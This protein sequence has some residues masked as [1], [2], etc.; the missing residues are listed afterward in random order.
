[1]KKIGLV[2]IGVILF[3]LIGT[4]FQAYFY[5]NDFARKHAYSKVLEY[6]ERKD[7]DPATLKGTISHETTGK[8]VYHFSWNYDDSGIPHTVGVWIAPDGYREIYSGRND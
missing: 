5:S 1:M 6:C 7:I 3:Y 8:F 4:S 2:I